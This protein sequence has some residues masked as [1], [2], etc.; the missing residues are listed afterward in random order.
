MVT[1][2]TKSL[3]FIDYLHHSVHI[4]LISEVFWALVFDFEH[5]FI[6]ARAHGYTYFKKAIELLILWLLGVLQALSLLHEGD[7]F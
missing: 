2:T 5:M 1:F 6:D 3:Y 4:L 7:L